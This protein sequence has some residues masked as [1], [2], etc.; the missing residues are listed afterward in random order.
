MEG[1]SIVGIRL[2][3]FEYQDQA[4]TKEVVGILLVREG[5]F[6][7]EDG[8]FVE[9]SRHS[10]MSG[11]A[12]T[13]TLRDKFLEESSVFFAQT[14]TREEDHARV[15]RLIPTNFVDKIKIKLQ[16]EEKLEKEGVES[17]S[18]VGLL[19]VKTGANSTILTRTFPTNQ[20][21][22]PVLFPSANS[23][24]STYFTQSLT[25]NGWDTAQSRAHRSGIG[26]IKVKIEEEK[27]YDDEINH[28]YEKVNALYFPGVEGFLTGSL[29]EE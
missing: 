23:Y 29:V 28:S 20:N 12:T 27:S 1:K 7:L 6:E 19:K 16:A 18:E 13:I 4:H 14:L 10:V 11:P 26:A 25:I 24:Q 2:H 21:W 9:A 5:Y 17:N 3:E 15:S 8:S 22:I